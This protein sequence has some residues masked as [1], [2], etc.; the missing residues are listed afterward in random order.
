MALLQKLATVLPM[1]NLWVHPARG[2]EGT[3]AALKNM[4]EAAR[5]MRIQAASLQ[6][7]AHLLSYPIGACVHRHYSATLPL[8]RATDL[9][10]PWAPVWQT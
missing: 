6:P 10:T 4:T 3:E 5:R 2:R 1:R 8:R 9:T 7:A